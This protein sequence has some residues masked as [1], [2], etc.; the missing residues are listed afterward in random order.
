MAAQ[1]IGRFG[2]QPTER[3]KHRVASLGV[4]SD[5]EP[6]ALLGGEKRQ[7]R[8]VTS[9][10]LMPH[11]SPELQFDQRVEIAWTVAGGAENLTA[12]AGQV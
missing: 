8:P 10:G 2:C 4:L 12:N 9:V 6:E 7:N 1:S 3:A 5:V 11:S